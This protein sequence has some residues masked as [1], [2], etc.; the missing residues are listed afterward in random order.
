MK[1]FLSGENV[2]NTG[3]HLMPFLVEIN[4]VGR[5]KVKS[6]K[7]SREP[8]LHH[9]TSGAVVERDFVFVVLLIMLL[10][11]GLPIGVLVL[12]FKRLTTCKRRSG[13]QATRI[14]PTPRKGGDE[15]Q[16]QE[17]GTKL[18]HVVIEYGLNCLD[19]TDN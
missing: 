10:M 8:G 5:G 13:Q 2:L 14:R 9:Y 6:W 18:S 7:T 12:L 15:K 11:T 1:T 19:A 4:E 17:S 16:K 3:E